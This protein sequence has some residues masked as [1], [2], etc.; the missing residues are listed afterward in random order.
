MHDEGAAV[1]VLGHIQLMPNTQ[2]IRQISATS[3]VSSTNVFRILHK[4]KFHP[5]KI[6][7]VHELNE[8]D[9]DKRQEFCEIM[10]DRLI[11]NQNLLYNICFSDESTFSLNGKVHRHNCRF[12]SDTNPHL[13]RE[14]HT[15]HPQKLNVWAGILGDHLIGPLFIQGNLNSE[16]YLNMMENEIDALITQTLEDDPLLAEQDLHFQQDGAPPH[17]AAPVRRHLDMRYPERWIGRRGPVE[18]PARSPDLNPLDFFCGD[19]LSRKFS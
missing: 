6:R 4:N 19:T 5:Y 13:Y 1:A 9:F 12:W 17:Y 8:D 15:Q 2:S 14:V 7:L 11:Q 10:S 18:W 3:G 16:M